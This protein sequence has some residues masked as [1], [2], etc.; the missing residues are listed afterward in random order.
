[1]GLHHVANFTLLTCYQEIRGQG[2]AAAF[3]QKSDIYAFGCILYRLCSLREPTVID[4]IE[5]LDI[6]VGYHIEL[7][8]LISSML[9]SERDARPT[10]TQVKDDLTAI[11]VKLFQT[12]TAAC[13]A[14]AETF[15][16]R[17]QLVK[18]LKKTGH[19][20]RNVD[21][22]TAQCVANN[23]FKNSESEFTIRGCA[24]APAQYYYD[25]H[26]LDTVDPSPCVVCNRYFNTKGQFFGHLGGVHHFRSAKYV[27]KRKA[28]LGLNTNTEREDERLAKRARKDMSR[29]D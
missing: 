13:R 28:E 26:E 7:I 23:E 17:N 24:D 2:Y 15:P 25:E 12:K 18:H 20:R 8:N 27:L 10:A 14:C 1:M 11:A 29:H 21:T 6:S 4:D 22:D 5:P 16:S 19:N 3:S 9:S